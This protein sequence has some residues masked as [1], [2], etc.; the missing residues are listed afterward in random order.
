MTELVLERRTLTAKG[1]AAFKRTEINVPVMPF[2]TMTH[3]NLKSF[4]LLYIAM[5]LNSVLS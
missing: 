4:Q 2:E 1:K 5:N 3:A